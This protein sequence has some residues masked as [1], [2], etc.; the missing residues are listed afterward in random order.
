MRSSPDKVF[1]GKVD[2][3]N[4]INEEA[5][6][7]ACIDAALDDNDADASN[8]LEKIKGSMIS[9]SDYLGLT[10]NEVPK[11]W[12][13]VRKPCGTGLVEILDEEYSSIVWTWGKVKS[14]RSALEDWLSEAESP[15]IPEWV[16]DILLEILA[17]ILKCET[18]DD[19]DVKDSSASFFFVLGTLLLLFEMGITRFSYSPIPI[20]SVPLS[21]TKHLL[22]DMA[23][24]MEDNEANR[25][26]ESTPFGLALLRILSRTNRFKE[27]FPL[28]SLSPRMILRGVGRGTTAFLFTDMSVSVAISEVASNEKVQNSDTS[29]DNIESQRFESHLWMQ[30]IV[31]HMETNLDDITGENL[32]FI[33][34]LLLQNGA[35]DAWVTPIVMKKGRPA[36]TLHCL[37]RENDNSKEIDAKANK[38][39]EIMFR[40]STTLGVRIYKDMLRAKLCR[41]MVTVQTPNEET[42]RK[43]LVDVKVSRFKNGEIISTKAEFD[44]CKEIAVEAGLPLKL[45]SEQAVAIARKNL[46]NSNRT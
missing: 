26:A 40:H 21:Y 43:G 38:L 35:I 4:G 11:S 42:T 5:L 10:T 8:I 14:V 29:N 33:I 12:K 20:Q 6:F 36:H 22:V 45:V 37:C 2:C 46:Q 3:K 24:S 31:T 17:L 25:S 18:E 23:V 41:S 44:H 30:D 28:E 7:A 15:K 16:K 32:A 39:L 19:G 13:F 34:D 1:H 27:P 9:V